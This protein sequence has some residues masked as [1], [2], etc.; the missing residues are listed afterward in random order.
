MG[1]EGLWWRSFAGFNLTIKL[2]V[3]YFTWL[4]SPKGSVGSV[5]PLVLSQVLFS[6]SP[7]RVDRMWTER[8]IYIR[9]ING[10]FTSHC[11]CQPVLLK[12]G[13]SQDCSTWWCWVIINKWY[14]RQ[15][16]DLLINGLE[17]LQDDALNIGDST[18]LLLPT[19]DRNKQYD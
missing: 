9:W 7:Y 12:Q 16:F 6:E 8:W 18:A 1:L 15:E 2:S 13:F 17:I 10:S 11:V 4:N 5:L 19:V 14:S 3:R